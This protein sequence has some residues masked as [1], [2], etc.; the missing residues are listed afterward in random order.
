MADGEHITIAKAYVEIIPSM[1][2]AKETISQELPEEMEKAGDKG[3]K[4]FGEKFKE[5]FGKVAKAVGETAVA[6]AGMAVTGVVALTKQ[7]VSSYAE[8]E[9]LEGGA[10]LLF[11]D[12]YDF[13]MK[14]SEEAYKTVQMSQNE[15]LAQVN[16][17]STGLKTSLNGDAQAAAELADRV[18]TAEADV[19]SATGASQEAVQ[20]AFNGIMKS[21]FSMLDNLQLGITPTK[22]GFQEIINK[23]NE[24]NEANGN[25][26]DYQI[27]NLADCQSAL[28]DYIE[29][30]GLANYASKEGT[31]TIQ[32]SLSSLG[33][34]WQNLLTG[35]ASGTSDLTP[36]IDN[37]VSSALN[38][39]DNISPV[40]QKVGSGLSKMISG[41]APV[42]EKTL[43]DLVKELLPSVST[44]VLSL[45]N[46]LVVILPSVTEA[47]SSL[48][49]QLIPTLIVLIPILI[50]GIF[51]LIQG[52]IDWLA[53]DENVT[54][55]VN[56]IVQ[57][58]TSLVNQFALLLPVLLPAIVHIIS[59]VA[60]TL[61]TP[62][63]I[64]LILDALL[65]VVGAI[66]VALAN[67]VPEIIDLVVG[68]IT[69]L[70]DLFA[71]FLEWIVPI[72]ALGVE[73]IVNTVKNWGTNIK[74]WLSN[75]ISNIKTSFSNW[76]NNIKTSFSSA[77]DSIKSKVSNI[78]TSIGGFVTNAINKFKELP[79]KI[80]SV[81]RDLI[82]GLWNGISD[83]A[84]WVYNKI[85]NMG[86]TIINKVKGIFG[87][88]SPSRVF[89]E[90][91]GFLS[92]GLGIGFEEEMKN[93]QSDMLDTAD[94]LT[95][96]MSSEITANTIPSD[97]FGSV[98]N[99][100]GSPISINVYGAE[101]QSVDS[102]ADA[103]AVKLEEMT[104]R[105]GVVYA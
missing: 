71:D 46:S 67:C 82:S 90:I 68:V 89:A 103:I 54:T 44:A 13:I 39:V 48:L 23:V 59:Q 75:L 58:V 85:S 102:L 42:I 91:G 105:R 69:N 63:N 8:F 72:V 22:A 65:T 104:R 96:S 98:S 73:G 79:S 25:A 51:T 41:L 55:L 76:L 37:V 70:S 1:S 29:M 88:H 36:L 45:V 17:L 35:L 94:G 40:V 31:S 78:L 28:V 47:L 74:N 95:A 24:W 10:K 52:L 53:S 93:V 16:G 33:G 21:N 27:E 15:Y 9:Q 101:G 19:V 83:K 20:N 80:V 32:G 64:K 2:S 61:T 92:E 66:V 60:Q 87:V 38:V 77:F 18:V 56:G 62:E 14:K 99:Y 50:S 7:A 26:T 30:Q 97:S 86:Q 81:G 4:K 5:G 100:N 11:G 43:P 57:M 34:A 49:T 12:G 84:T 6:V 3:G